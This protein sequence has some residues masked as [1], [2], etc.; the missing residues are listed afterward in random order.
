MANRT[1][2]SS[3]TTEMPV[4]TTSDSEAP[5]GNSAM[6]LWSHRNC[7][8]RITDRASVDLPRPGLF[9][10]DSTRRP[11]NSESGASQDGHEEAPRAEPVRA[12]AAACSRGT[13]GRPMSE[14]SPAHGSESG[15]PQARRRGPDGTVCRRARHRGGSGLAIRARPGLLAGS[16]A[17]SRQVNRR[18]RALGSAFQNRS[19]SIDGFSVRPRLVAVGVVKAGDRPPSPAPRPAYLSTEVTGGEF[20]LQVRSSL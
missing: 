7:K 4:W 20:L 9:P 10:R 19:L 1:A 2:F 6:S 17:R 12:G 11:A 16:E 15:A 5:S 8:V 18:G 3:L 13:A 14:R